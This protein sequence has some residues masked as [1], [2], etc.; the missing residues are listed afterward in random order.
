MIT[1]QQVKKCSTLIT[2]LRTRFIFW[3]GTNQNYREYATVF[4]LHK[5]KLVNLKLLTVA[6]PFN[7]WL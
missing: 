6:W 4:P 1:A 2:G 7:S 5:I 3:S